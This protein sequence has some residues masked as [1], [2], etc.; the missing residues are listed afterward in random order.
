MIDLAGPVRAHARS[1]LPLG[2]KS[3]PA[4]QRGQRPAAAATVHVRVVQSDPGPHMANAASG[5]RAA[6]AAA[7]VLASR[8]R[9]GGD[10]RVS[11]DTHGAVR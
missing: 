6:L 4:A 8:W 3:L 5:R 10:C 1:T 7:L 2:A 11:L 9:E